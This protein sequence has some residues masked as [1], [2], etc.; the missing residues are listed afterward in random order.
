MNDKIEKIKFNS[1]R[2]YITLTYS[3]SI[4][5]IFAKRQLKIKRITNK[6]QEI[7][8]SEIIAALIFEITSHHIFLREILPNYIGCTVTPSH[9]SSNICESI[10][11][12]SAFVCTKNII[13]NLR[14]TR[15]AVRQYWFEPGIRNPAGLRIFYVY[16]TGCARCC[17]PA[18][19]S[20]LFT[21]DP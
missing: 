14:F 20:P 16:D 11:E 5:F 12:N 7:S 10:I 1:T 9:V 18:P 6:K 21:T 3:S 19:V 4:R 13:A 15:R 8:T 17:W 2:T